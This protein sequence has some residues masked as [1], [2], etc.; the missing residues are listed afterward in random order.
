MIHGQERRL[1]RAPQGDCAASPGAEARQSG[2]PG[3][4]TAVAAGP[5][6]GPVGALAR[7]A[8]APL[9]AFMQGMMTI[10]AAVC[11]RRIHVANRGR[12]PARGL[13]LFFEYWRRE[14]AFDPA[15]RRAFNITQAG[16]EERWRTRTRRRY[17]ALAL[18]AD[19]TLAALLLLFLVMPLYLNRRRRDRQRLEAMARAEEDQERRERESA[20]EA[21]LRSVASPE[22]RGESPSSGG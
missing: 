3:D 18:F 7:A 22:S 11:F 20:I 13:T 6:A 9:Y 15:V 8:A 5:P 19:L 2:S 12:F 14:G 4:R 17:G 1:R 21:L 10:A 16:F